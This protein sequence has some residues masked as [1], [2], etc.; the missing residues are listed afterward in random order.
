[1]VK[2]VSMRVFLTG[3]NGWVGSAITR[4]LLDAGHTVVGLVRSKE[5]GE[6]LAAAGGTPLLGSLSDL[7][8]LREGASHADSVIHTAFGLDFSKIL[9]LSEEDREAIETFGEAFA[10]SDRPIVV[11]SGLGLLP[12][13]ETFTEDARPPIIPAFPRA[14][15]QT[16]FALAERGLRASVVRLSRSTHGVGER[17]GFVPM[18]AAV[19]REKGKSA[20]VGD[21]QNLWPAVHRL[22]AARVFRLALE[23]GGRNEAFHAVAEGVPFRL[24]AEAIGRQVGVPA[25]SLTPEEA[26][27]HFGG[28]AVWV[29]GSGPASSEMTRAAL[30]WEPREIGII[31]D[32]DRPEY[33]A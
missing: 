33:Y 3:A 21:G 12:P 10:G 16:A 32:I 26:E 24:I 29:A 30:G 31:S 4:E 25:R 20:Y 15:E 2:E 7:G 22:D 27:T 28:L 6:A 19:A 23:R 9:E 11:T 18:L 5:N 13:G 8:V 1:M 14:S 17:H